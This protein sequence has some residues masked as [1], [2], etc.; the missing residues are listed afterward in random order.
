[1]SMNQTISQK[2]KHSPAKETEQPLIQKSEQLFTQKS[3]QLL[4]Q[5]SVHLPS[6]NSKQIP[7]QKVK[8]ISYIN[9]ALYAFGGL[10]IE[11]I[12]AF[13][14]EPKIYG[15]SMEDW[16]VS[17]SILHWIITCITWGI[18][19]F[20]LY[21]FAKVKYGFD[22]LKQ[23]KVKLQVWQ[24]IC[25]LLCIGL[26]FY[27]S[28]T[29]WNGFKPLIEYQ[30]LGLTKFIFQYLYYAFET[31]LFMLI[32]IFGQ[33]AFETWFGKENI[34][35]GGIVVAATWGLVHILTKGSIS[36][37]VLSALAGFSFGVVYLLLN[38]DIKKTYPV[39][40]IMFLI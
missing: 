32:L 24:W 11:V 19:T 27:S 9:L 16:S 17:Q 37:G 20:I 7:T 38:R 25:T 34:P 3:E 15:S 13:I 6:Q 40:L 23:R 10:G 2:V 26:I 29:S 30:N 31:S 22:L 14:L 12:Y 18:V 5:K 28:Y 33:K 36:T 1:M 21:R 4:T 35:Y 39:L 8:G